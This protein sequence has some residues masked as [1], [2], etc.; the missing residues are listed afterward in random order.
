MITDNYLRRGYTN[1]QNLLRP[2]TTIFLGDL[3]DGGREWKTAYGDFQD[4]SWA[5][6]H[7][8]G[9][10][11][12]VEAWHKNYGEDFWLKEYT[13]FNDIFF[14]PFTDLSGTKNGDGQRGRKIIASLPG[15]HDL[16]FGDQV[17]IPV[18][19]RFR[20]YFGEENRI[21]IIG[22]HTIVSVDTVSL[23]ADTSDAI[24]QHDE[25]LKKVYGPARDFLDRIQTEKRKAIEQELRFWRGETVE[26]SYPHA[27]EDAN[28]ASFDHAPTMDPGEAVTREDFPTILLTH[29]PLYRKPGTPCGPMREHWPPSRPLPGQDGPVIPDHPNAISISAGYQYQNVLSEED[30]VRLVKSIGNVKHVFSGDDHDYC[31]LNHNEAKEFVKEITVKSISMAMGVPTPGFLMVSLWNPVDVQTGRS[32][33]AARNEGQDKSDT[34]EQLP[35]IQTHLCLLPQQLGTFMWYAILAV[36]TI[37]LCAV[38]AFL[39]PIIGLVPFA[40]DESDSGTK[41]GTSFLPTHK[42]KVEEPS[43]N[44]PGRHPPGY[45]PSLG[46]GSGRYGASAG[47]LSTRSPYN[48]TLEKFASGKGGRDYYGNGR[49]GWDGGAAVTPQLGSPRIEIPRD[50]DDDGFGGSSIYDA[51]PSQWQVRRKARYGIGAF[52]WLGRHSSRKQRRVGGGGGFTFKE[53]GREFVAC[54]WRVIWMAGGLWVWLNMKG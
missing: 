36:L 6:P 31:E 20:A 53:V 16:G 47:A 29:V 34:T 28:S 30:S 11:S 21:D 39:V 42:V 7:P 37:V 1:L 2:D 40:L 14:K 9:E 43:H 24:K 4:P 45:I 5:K 41:P 38:R 19:D 15:N 50:G 10:A 44:L 33:A 48:G 46:G 32:L 26:L 22:N 52:S 3:F 17:K 23:S 8:N 35:T 13:R 18:R 54:V 51:F 49:W 12:F 25:E 27:V